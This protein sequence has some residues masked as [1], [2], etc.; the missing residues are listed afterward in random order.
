M[1]VYM[2]FA[3]KR[4]KNTYQVCNS[5]RRY[6][7]LNNDLHTPIGWD[8]QTPLTNRTSTSNRGASQWVEPLHSWLAGSWPCVGGLEERWGPSIA[9]LHRHPWHRLE[10]ETGLLWEDLLG[11]LCDKLE[12][13]YASKQARFDSWSNLCAEC[14]LWKNLCKIKTWQSHQESTYNYGRQWGKTNRTRHGPGSQTTIQHTG[15]GNFCKENLS[16]SNHFDHC[17]FNSAYTF[18]MGWLLQP[19]MH[20]QVEIQVPITIKKVHCIVQLRTKN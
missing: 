5:T 20:C 18:R 11:R 3:K 8:R 16:L 7:S 4:D 13:S 1:Y 6:N 10:E 17:S 12:R 9:L 2:C 15:K 14:D 19:C